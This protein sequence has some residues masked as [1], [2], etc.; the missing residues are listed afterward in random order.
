MN[1]QRFKTLALALAVLAFGLGQANAALRA[2][3]CV[4]TCSAE[5]CAGGGGV[6]GFVDGFVLGATG[7]KGG[8]LVKFVCE[9]AS[10]AAEPAWA[11]AQQKNAL[12][13]SIAELAASGWHVDAMA[14]A[15]GHLVLVVSK[16]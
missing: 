13:V 7:Y 9:S 8:P 6:D 3:L 1:I 11:Q 12:R 10:A 15:K 5:N 14:V 16:K 4:S 2:K